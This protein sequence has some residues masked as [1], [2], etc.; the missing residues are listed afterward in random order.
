MPL[1]DLLKARK[2]TLPPVIGIARPYS[3]AHYARIHHRSQQRTERY[4]EDIDHG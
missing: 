1:K 4:L 2:Y 3:R